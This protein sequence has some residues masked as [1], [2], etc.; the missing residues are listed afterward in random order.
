MF[1]WLVNL[2]KRKRKPP[3]PSSATINFGWNANPVGDN[4][5]HYLLHRSF[6]SGVYTDS[7]FDM[8]TALS[9]SDTITTEG[10]Y[11][12]ALTA[13]NAFGISSLSSEIS[14]HVYLQ[15]GPYGTVMAV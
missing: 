11:F 1:K 7:G 5:T 14:Q 8:G 4:V 12:W 15:K 10:V 3:V 13:Q 6:V 2:F 9:G